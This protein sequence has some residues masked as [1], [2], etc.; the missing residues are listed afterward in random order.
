MSRQDQIKRL[1]ANH[2]RRLQVLEEKKALYGLDTAP[3]IL[4]EIEDIKAT[5]AELEAELAQVEHPA[6]DIPTP[7]I[8]HNLPPRSEFVGRE[9]EKT[10]LHEA[11]LSRSRLVSVDGIGGIGKTALALEVVYECLQA[12]QAKEPTNEIATFDGFIWTTAKDRELNL[13]DLLDTIALTLEYPGLVQKQTKEKLNAVDKLLRSQPYLLIVD[14]Y[15]NITD[16]NVRGFLV[17]LSEPSR[18][19]I[20]SR[21]R[22]LTEAW[23]ISLEDL[24]ETDALTLIRNEGRR[25]GLMAVVNV[26]TEVLK[27]LYQ[28]TGGTP[29]AIKWAV[30]Q[31]KQKGQSLDSVLMALQEAQGDIFEDLFARSWLF[32]PDEAQRVLM[33]MPIFVTPVP[34]DAIET[35]A[36][37]HSLELEDAIGQLVEMSL[38]EVS[39][40]LEIKKRRYHVHPLVRSFARTQLDQQPALKQDFWQRVTPYFLTIAKG[41]KDIAVDKDAWA[42][43]DEQLPNVLNTIDWCF[44]QS[45]KDALRFFETIAYYLVRR[46]YWD[47][48]LALGTEAYDLAMTLSNETDDPALKASYLKQA[49]TFGLRHVSWIYRK[50]QDLETSEK[51]CCQSIAIYEKIGDREGLARARRHLGRIYQENGQFANAERIFKMALEDYQQ[52]ERKQSGLAHTWL[53]LGRIARDQGRYEEAVELINEGLR[54]CEETGSPAGAGVSLLTLGEIALTLNNFG[55]ARKHYHQALKIM[56]EIERADRIADAKLGLARVEAQTGNSATVRRLAQ[57][58]LE[59]Y[60]K[61]G[62][63]AKVEEAQTL[64][65]RLSDSEISTET[66][67]RSNP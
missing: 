8:L 38:L 14:N 53:S 20:T 6:A 31:I 41:V 24:P 4:I 21:E 65:D 19:L 28:A 43:L 67:T 63:A 59:I 37:I 10:Q 34:R 27:R 45:P 50:R 11:L 22:N 12:S 55:E 48:I 58:A 44:T 54:L 62:Q 30:G 2:N 33:L 49:A 5:L 52:L 42:I 36:D 26:D 32:L 35:A 7:G 17:R 23:M 15:E 60:Q 3:D 18:V 39:D 66:T 56:Q 13:N 57:E 47:D 61:L 9:N 51:W 25:L 46:G 64:L 1:I 40:H 16:E 29:L